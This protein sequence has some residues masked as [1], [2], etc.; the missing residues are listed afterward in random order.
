M[1]MI[2]NDEIQ[3]RLSEVEERMEQL[4]RVVESTSELLEQLVKQMLEVREALSRPPQFVM[5]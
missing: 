4:E 3:A 1:D 5:S 2:E